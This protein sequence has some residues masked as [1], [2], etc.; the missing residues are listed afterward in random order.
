MAL[1][2]KHASP[3]FL[4]SLPR[5]PALLFVIW[6]LRILWCSFIYLC[7]FLHAEEELLTKVLRWALEGLAVCCATTDAGSDATSAAT[8]AAALSGAP[9]LS[10]EAAAAAAAAAVA[11]AEE[12]AL[13][14]ARAVYSLGERRWIWVQGQCSW[15]G[16]LWRMPCSAE[17]RHVGNRL[18]ST[19][20]NMQVH[21]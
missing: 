20:R 10:A 3:C 7:S 12:T 4:L 8:A 1:P 2:P 5:F 16:I 15:I 21:S 14:E 9:P 13:I 17:S 19:N 11:A 18:P 6:N